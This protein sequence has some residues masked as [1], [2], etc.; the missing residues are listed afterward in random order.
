MDLRNWVVVFDLDD[1]LISEIE[2]Q[3]S[4]IVAVESAISSLYGV[5][6]DGLIQQALDEGIQD[7]W[8]WSCAKLNLPSE[9]KTSFLWL[10]RLHFPAIKAVS[11]IRS[12]LER[13]SNAYANL[14][15]LTDGRSITQRLKLSAVGLDSIPLFVSEDYQSA[16]PRPERF[17]AIEKRWP[18]CRYVYVADNPIKD[19]L[20]PNVR[21]WL[22]IGANWVN[23]KIHDYDPEKLGI[24]YR[25]MHWLSEPVEIIN[26]INAVR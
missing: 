9:V 8:G 20:V 10:Y 26:L 17:I 18:D 22:T 12:T 3:R 24:T 16:K 14:A 7:I 13:L 1:T 2:Y 25:P 23:P 11:G 6:F 5:A 4:G 15:V 19:F 21:G